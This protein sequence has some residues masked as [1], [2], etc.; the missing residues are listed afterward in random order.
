MITHDDAHRFAEDWI[1][2]W[3]A[4]DLDRILAHYCDDF[5]MASP[6]IVS[7]MSDPCGVLRGKD[8]VRTYWSQALARVPNLCFELVGVYAGV[9]SVVI[10]YD[11]PRGRGA[12]AFWLDDAGKVIRAAAHYAEPGAGD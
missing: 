5:E 11:G 1:A 2:A 6:V 7:L 10:L 9:E 8:A 3:N 4:R 12:E